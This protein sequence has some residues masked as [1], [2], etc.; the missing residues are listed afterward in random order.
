MDFDK[1]ADFFD[2]YVDWDR[3]LAKEMPC[4]I[5][6]IR[7]NRGQQVADVA[8]GSG[9]HA[10]ALSKAGFSVTAIDANPVLLNKAE[11]L[12]KEKTTELRIAMAKFSD[13]P[14]RFTAVF[15][16]V[17]CMGNSLSLVA[18]GKELE[19]ALR[20]IA[21]M[22][23]PSGMFIAHTLNY[24]ML[25]GREEDPWG[26]VRI[27]TDGSLLLKGFIPCHE[28]PWDALFLWIEKQVDTKW[29]SHPTRFK[30]YPHTVP[31]LMKAAAQA[32]LIFRSVAGG[33]KNESVNDPGSADLLYEFE[34]NQE[35]SDLD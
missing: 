10:V 21:H 18:P 6:R 34:K 11:K 32:G 31:D 26:P 16:A 30:I 35:V 15:D 14:G 5:S 4:I 24:P 13:L 17:I 20:G 12:A 2:L 29:V 7:E 25:A 8:C 1:A 28:G 23:R 19:Q 9:M 22:L 27:L 3:R 33:F